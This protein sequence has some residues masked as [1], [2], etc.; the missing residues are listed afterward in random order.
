MRPANRASAVAFGETMRLALDALR[1]HKLRTF[2]TLLGVILSVFTLVLV[3][4][5]V[6]GLNRYISK[7]VANLGA[8]TLIITKFGIITNFE[9]FVK[10]Q[11]RPPLR[12]E[13]YEY[14]KEHLQLAQQVGASASRGPDG[15][16]EV[17]SGNEAVEDVDVA[18]GTSNIAELRGFTVALGRFLNDT[19]DTH[20]SP[21]CIIGNDLV[22]RLFPQVDP[23]GKTI[24]I[25]TQTYQVVGTANPLGSVFG[26]SRDNWVIMPYQ[27]FL[28]SWHQPN[29]SIA[30]WVQALSP[31]MMEASADEARA[32][33]RAHRRVPYN[34]P[35]N[36]GIVT[37]GSIT[38][39]WTTLTGN[40]FGLAIMLT[41]VFLVVGG[42][43]IMNIMLASVTERTREIGIRKSLG[44]RR[45]H[46]V[47]QF[48]VESAVMSAS[49]GLIGVLAGMAVTALVRNL[50][51]MPAATPVSAVVVSLGLA[52]SVGL[53]FGIYPAVRASRLDPVDA[54]RF[55]V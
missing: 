19:D 32:I 6:E 39:V 27:T 41:S 34:D 47:M 8:N 40:L 48:M 28:K 13:D 33:L 18:G 36:F 9:D 1:A 29:D 14:L 4:S 12:I 11:R 49:G 50:T 45:R 5:V 38:E 22:E 54:L 26:Q 23:I 44:A 46:I 24:R 30:V 51:F 52:T 43:V 17:R 55:E 25:G 21:V 2:L 10:A 35:D 31:E 16:F 20:R 15:R 53:F 42:I 3:M 7:Q 37:N